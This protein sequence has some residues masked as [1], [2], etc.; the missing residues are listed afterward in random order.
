MTFFGGNMLLEFVVRVA[1]DDLVNKG[2][3]I[4]EQ[5]YSTSPRLNEGIEVGT[6]DGGTEILPN[7]L[8]LFQ[9][10]LAEIPKRPGELQMTTI[11]RNSISS[12]DEVR[13]YLKECN[14]KII[15]GWPLTMAD[16]PCL[17]IRI[18]S[19][20]A[21]DFI[22][23]S[24]NDI[25]NPDGRYNVFGAEFDSTYVMSIL[26]TNEND[27]HAWHN[28]IKYAL[29]RYRHVLDAYGMKTIGQSWGDVA[30]ATEYLSAGVYVFQRECT[31]NC[32]KTDS[33]S[34]KMDGF[35]TI[36]EYTTDTGL[37]S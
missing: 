29:I 22:G 37:I 11:F 5:I 30:P 23:Q 6:E 4:L 31:V 15:H 35:S 25:E 27:I 32:K 8:D 9:A 18:E 2:P 10:R 7:D 20:N 33:F 12:V 34:V 21:D 26:S 13:Q 17:S 14:I 24:L 3:Y 16:L 28:L 1:Y 36:Q 19:E